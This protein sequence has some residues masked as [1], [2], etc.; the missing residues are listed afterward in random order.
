MLRSTY[1]GSSERSPIPGVVA[2]KL[3]VF[4]QTSLN[5]FSPDAPILTPKRPSPV[6]MLFMT[7][8]EAERM[9]M[10]VNLVSSVLFVMDRLSPAHT[11][12]PPVTVLAPRMRLFRIVIPRPETTFIPY[13]SVMEN[14]SF[15][16]RAV[17]FVRKIPPAPPTLLITVRVTSSEEFETAI[18]VEPERYV[19]CTSIAEPFRTAIRASELSGDPIIR[20]S[21]ISTV[22]ARQS[23]VPKT[24]GSGETLVRCEM[25]TPFTFEHATGLLDNTRSI[26]SSFR[27]VTPAPLPRSSR[28]SRS[29]TGSS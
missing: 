21:W 13:A 14:L 12:I 18:P 27:L 16:I 24:S 9:S 7:L 10:P 8:P 6:M 2:E 29:W 15:V 19:S 22:D 4:P 20:Q 26:E 3:T 25:Q 11:S 17:E 23:T 5:E 28:L 1:L